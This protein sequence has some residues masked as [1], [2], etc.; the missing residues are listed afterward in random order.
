MEAIFNDRTHAVIETAGDTGSIEPSQS[1]EAI[2]Q[3]HGAGNG[4]GTGSTGAGSIE[5]S[6]LHGALTQTHVGGRIGF[7][8]FTGP[9]Q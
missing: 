2:T 1:H 6:Q 3:T 9:E 5:P 7:T 8:G 4:T